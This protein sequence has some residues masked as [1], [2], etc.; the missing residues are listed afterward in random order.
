MKT[1]VR[2]IVSRAAFYLFTAWAAIT[3][4]FFLPRMMKGDP[5]TAYM[6]KNAGQ[7]TPE[8]ERALRILFGLDQN[9][10]LWQQYL[11]YWGLLFSGDLGRSFSNGLAPVADVIASALPWTLG[12]VGFATILSFL[13]G[14][15]AG[16][17][18]GWRRGSRADVIVPI[19]TFFSTVPYFWLGLIAI[20]VF[21]SV[22][23][24]FPASHAYDKGARP[25]FTFDF[26]AQVIAH[27]TL[28]A[29]T[30]IVASLGGW[31]L[32]MRNM[33]L[34]VLDEDYV[35][36][37]QAKG[38]PNDRVLWRYAARN[39]MLPQLS[40]FALSL[41]FIVGGTIVM[42]MVFSY[43]GVGKLLLD[44]TTAKDYPLMQG[45][46]LIITLAVLLAN[47]LA[48]IA[49]AVLDPRTRQTEA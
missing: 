6:Q 23:G 8:A 26:V 14:T 20:A 49:H 16:A 36:V 41:G 9:T 4:N 10:S 44:A 15:A 43:P 32:G 19:S 45:L 42:E 5:V 35:T 34:T 28:P 25:A 47:I 17:L 46:F 11:D 21:S 30:I 12:L 33:M 3:I 13:L 18:I 37:A 48:D 1:N 38:M 39:A 22:L 29:L 2:F 40:S 31:I 7:I 27:G 24:W